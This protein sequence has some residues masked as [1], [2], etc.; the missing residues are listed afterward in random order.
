MQVPNRDPMSAERIDFY[1][2]QNTSC[3]SPVKGP[4]VCHESSLY[5]LCLMILAFT[6]NITS[7]AMFVA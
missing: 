5:A 6:R 7:S 2:S 1:F 3:N 4:Q